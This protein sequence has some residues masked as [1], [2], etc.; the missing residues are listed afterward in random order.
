MLWNVD[1][2]IYF[3]GEEEAFPRVHRELT[4]LKADLA[5][6]LKKKIWRELSEMMAG[7]TKNALKTDLAGLPTEELQQLVEF[8]DTVWELSGF[9]EDVTQRGRGG[10]WLG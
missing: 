3:L 5:G 1:G 10:V 7:Q 4:E 9:I 6:A 2:V 8:L